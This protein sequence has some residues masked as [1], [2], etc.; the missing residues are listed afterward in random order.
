M[1]SI[2]LLRKLDNVISASREAAVGET[3]NPRK[4]MEGSSK[5]MIQTK[6]KMGSAVTHT[7]RA[8][9]RARRKVILRHQSM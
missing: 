7:H 2:T 4:L 5:S 1:I 3:V 9:S 6:S 8:D